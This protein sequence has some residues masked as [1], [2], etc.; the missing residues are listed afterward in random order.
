MTIA[1]CELATAGQPIVAPMPLTLFELPLLSASRFAGCAGTA[2]AP[3]L[4]DI[5]F[6]HASHPCAGVCALFGNG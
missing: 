4:A 6:D 5:L 1:A 3:V 2:L